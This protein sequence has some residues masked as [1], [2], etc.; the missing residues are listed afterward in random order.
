VLK[1]PEMI[2]HVSSLLAQNGAKS[3]PQ[4]IADLRARR[5]GASNGMTMNYLITP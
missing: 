3:A 5:P 1:D 2:P 4:I